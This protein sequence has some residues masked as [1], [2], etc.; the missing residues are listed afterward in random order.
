MSKQ[1]LLIW[2]LLVLMPASTFAAQNDIL[3]EM[4]TGGQQY[5]EI[6]DPLEP[7]NRVFF[8]FNDTMFTYVLNPVAKTYA[9][10]LPSEVRGA[11][12]NAFDNLLAPIRI[13]NS[14]LQ[15]KIAQSGTE[16]LRFVI[17]T[18]AGVGGLGDPAKI[19]FGLYS[20]EEDLG[21]TLGRYGVGDGVYICWPI[22]GP[23]NIRD[24]VGLV[25]DSFLNPLSYLFLDD[26][27]VGLAVHAGKRVN[28]TS[29]ALGEYEQFIESSFD[30]Y[31][32][33]R[34]YYTDSRHSQI[35]DKHTSSKAFPSNRAGIFN[36]GTGWLADTDKMPEIHSSVVESFAGKKSKEYFIQ[37]GACVEKKN[38]D[39][40]AQRVL[41]FGKQPVIVQ[42]DRKDY[43]FYGIQVK[44]GSD[45]RMAKVT[46]QE[47]LNDGFTETMVVIR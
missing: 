46:E 43:S 16:L 35:Q 20:A 26:A 41:S 5:A 28:Q 12:G 18:T 22:L 23:S 39:A 1:I 42:Y 10:V 45:F 9:A 47:L 15:G 27:G 44:S 29:L 25:G 6:N 24:T 21:Q 38:V 31:I 36:F 30:P 8:K 17:N 4:D 14:L 2:V 3:D 33:M 34:D 37:V 40:L 11:V 13:V 7:I 19:S 32:A